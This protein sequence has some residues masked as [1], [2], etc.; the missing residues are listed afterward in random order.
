MN[1][2]LNLK[3]YRDDAAHALSCSN[4]AASH[5]TVDLKQH[6]L[7]VEAKTIGRYKKHYD[8]MRKARIYKD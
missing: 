2:V 7:V 1:V 3:S 4:F 6:Y 8:M 5:E